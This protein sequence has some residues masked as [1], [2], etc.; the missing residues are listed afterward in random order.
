MV[1]W[2][3]SAL[4]VCLGRERA[5]EEG[6][7]TGGWARPGHGPLEAPGRSLEDSILHPETG[8]GWKPFKAKG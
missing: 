5:G 3:E 7:D 6:D 4:N 2:V 1:I 8:D